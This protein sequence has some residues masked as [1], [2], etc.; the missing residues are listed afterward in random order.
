MSGLAS[1]AEMF[2]VL[3]C[4]GIVLAGAAI[5]MA[6]AACLVSPWYWLGFAVIVVPL[7]AVAFLVWDARRC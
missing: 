1:V 3:L 2:A 7:A 5:G 6:M 4:A